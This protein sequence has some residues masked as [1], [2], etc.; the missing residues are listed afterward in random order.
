MSIKSLGYI[1]VAANDTSDWDAFGTKL[2][3]MQAVNE[4]KSL[5]LRMDERAR[6]MIIEPDNYNGL[7]YF[8]LEVENSDALNAMAAKL[9]AAKI[10]ITKEPTGLVL[11]RGAQEVISFH[12]PMGNRVEIFYGGEV[13]S[14]EF[15]PGRSIS[16]FRTGNLGLGHVVLK[17]KHAEPMIKFYTEVI[18]FK[19]SD[20][21]LRPFKAYFFHFNARHHSFAIVESDE[22]GVHHMMVEM[23]S[24]DDVG[25]GYDLALLDPDKNIGVTLGRHSNDY[26]TSFYFKSPAGFLVEYGWG[27]R[28]IT[29]TDWEAI[30][31]EYGPSL[32]GHE[33]GWLPAEK[34][35][36]A[37]DLRIAGAA[38]GIRAPSHVLSGYYVVEE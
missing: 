5:S 34:R 29:T 30:E 35:Q 13:A 11:S 7:K 31:Y 15:V 1:G 17:V 18:G 16:G 20:Y 14:A 24:L 38:K 9:E 37:R 26:M 33:R 2:L 21:A 22:N 19:L 6:R 8:G 12:D 3:G 4:G 10:H 27:G 25:Q 36:E 23:N 32:W 28:S